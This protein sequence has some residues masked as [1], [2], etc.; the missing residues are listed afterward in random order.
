MS[1]LAPLL[2]VRALTMRYDAEAGAVD[3]L[4]EIAFDV[5]A[6]EFVVL[7]GRSGSGKSTLLNLLGAMDRPCAGTIR[8]GDIELTAL[9]EPGRTRFRR[10][11]LGFI[12][13]AY[14]LIPTLSARENVALPLSLNGLGDGDVEALL[15]ELGL[16]GRGGAYPDQLSGGEQQRVAI[17]RALAHRPRLILADEP[18]GN[19][20]AQTSAQVL[21][22]LAQACRDKGQ[23]LVMA[24]HSEDALRHAD[25]ALQLRQGT[26][27][28]L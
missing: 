25:R 22:L 11:H 13:Q 17:A 8:M 3:V 16:A 26:L 5:A 23:T 10:R 27:H 19:L 14:N 24:T 12:F 2:Q 1:A 28:P 7:L 15:A 9:D 6:G 4:R 18:T 21:A 20:D